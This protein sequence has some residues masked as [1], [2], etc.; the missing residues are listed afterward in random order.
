MERGD[1]QA[2]VHGVY[3]SW[4]CK[5]DKATAK[6]RFKN[7]KNKQQVSRDELFHSPLKL[8]WIFLVVQWWRVHLPMQGV[9]VQSLI[10]EDSWCLGEAGPMCYSYLALMPQLLKPTCSEDT[11]LQQ[12]SHLSVRLAHHQGWIAVPS[13]HNSF[14]AMKPAKLKK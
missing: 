1:W 9:W 10:W 3:I 7:L 8:L 6:V 5:R 12:G 2:T 13:C 11:D 14:T 4:G